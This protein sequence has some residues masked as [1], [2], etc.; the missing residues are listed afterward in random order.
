MVPTAVRLGAMADRKDK[1]H[2]EITELFAELWQVPRFAGLHRGFRPNVDSFHTEEPHELTI[3]V[4][5]P[6]VEPSSLRI[7]IDE[8]TLT[9]AGERIRPRAEGVVYEQMEIEYG[10]FRRQVR[11]TEDIDPDRA[12]AHYERGVLT[13]SLPIPDKPAPLVGRYTIVVTRL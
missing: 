12:T 10:A 7:L 11:L 3:V 1:L 6:G 4:E 13:V 5:V 2:E 8:R 9:I